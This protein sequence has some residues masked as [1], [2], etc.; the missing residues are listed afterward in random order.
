[1]VHALVES[2]LMLEKALCGKPL[3]QK[4]PHHE[5]RRAQYIGRE[6]IF[7]LLLPEHALVVR[8]LVLLR[9]KYAEALAFLTHDLIGEPSMR[10]WTFEYCRDS[11]ARGNTQRTQSAER[12][13]MNDVNL[14]CKLL[15]TARHDV[16]M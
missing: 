8:V 11:K 16:I 4:R 12:P 3:I 10:I 14:S 15:E 7:R 13:R 5:F 2:V 1:M 9:E 6:F